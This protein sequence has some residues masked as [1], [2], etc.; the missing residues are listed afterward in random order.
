MFLNTKILNFL[1]KHN[2]Y[3][4]KVTFYFPTACVTACI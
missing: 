4:I 3:Y 2:K 1:I